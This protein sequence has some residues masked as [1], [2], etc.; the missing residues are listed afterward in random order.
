M[1]RNMSVAS[2]SHGFVSLPSCATNVALGINAYTYYNSDKLALR[3][4]HARPVSQA[5]QPTLYRIVRELATSAR[6][7]KAAP[8]T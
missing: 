6:L 7:S 8:V 2:P 1:A 3:A 5:E 4:M